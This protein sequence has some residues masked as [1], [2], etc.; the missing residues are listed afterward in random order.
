MKPVEEFKKG[1]N[2][3]QVNT[4]SGNSPN[5]SKC[6]RTIYCIQTTLFNEDEPYCK[7]CYDSLIGELPSR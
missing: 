4:H 1:D 2:M 3:V 7:K 6:A 5:C